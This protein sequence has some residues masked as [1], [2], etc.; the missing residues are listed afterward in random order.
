MQQAKV[1]S[2][3]EGEALLVAPGGG[4]S[5]R[6]SWF[7][8]AAAAVIF[9]TAAIFALA[10]GVGGGSNDAHAA[11]LG[12]N[13]H[14]A[15]EKPVPAVDRDHLASMTPTEPPVIYI[16]DTEDPTTSTGFDRLRANVAN[17][18]VRGGCTRTSCEFS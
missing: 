8:Y 4:G 10:G 3:G 18:V 14:E 12:D 9:G 2:E 13:N 7:V 15:Q 5:T 17:V 1:T 11:L 16:A 6:R